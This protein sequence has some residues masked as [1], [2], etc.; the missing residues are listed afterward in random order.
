MLLG[1]SCSICG[2]SAK[3]SARVGV[4]ADCAREGSEATL[5][6][7][8][9][10]HMEV[11]K[12]FG[13]P[14]LPP[15]SPGGLKCNICS[16]SCSMAPGEMG[17]CGL[18]RNGEGRMLNIAGIDE[19][20]AFHYLDPH[21]TNC[22]SRWFCPGGTG[23]GYPKIS[24]RPSAELGYNNLAIFLFGCNFSCL[25]C[26]NWEHKLLNKARR[27]KVQELVERTLKDKSIT[28]WCFFGGS[29]EPQLPS[30]ISASKTILESI[31]SG[32]LLRIC[33]EWNGCGN[34]VLVL[35]ASDISLRTGGNV[36]FDLKCWSEPLSLLLSGVSNRKA[37]EN[38]ELVAGKLFDKREEPVITATTLLVPWYVDEEEVE[39]IAKFISSINEKIPYSLLVFHPNFVM[40]D[41]PITPKDQVA[42]C[43]RAA[44]MHLRLVNVGNIHLLG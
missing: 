41:L 11:R 15:S 40:N 10:F 26:Q 7:A 4:C 1:T 34:S 19:I 17:F 16:N 38:F 39:G 20:L 35:N 18:R 13:L 36:K 43:L 31:P 30:C 28:C 6:Y 33:F 14:G 24:L 37:F 22:C 2:S 12:S 27:V 3:L 5:L 42:R 21:P 9:R 32:R 29:P 44:K 23:S 8:K 25:Y